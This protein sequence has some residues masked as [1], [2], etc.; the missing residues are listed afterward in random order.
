MT[1]IGYG[2]F[3]RGT[4]A[5]LLALLV[6]PPFAG[7]SSAATASAGAIRGVLY[8][9]D[10][11]TRL[12]AATVTAINVKTGRRYV[13]NHTGDNGAYEIT[14]LPAGTYDIAI[15][16][17]ERVFVTDNLIDLAENQ[18]LYLSFA[19][20]PK[21]TAAPGATEPTD[22][23]GEA[24][25]TFTDP[26][27]VPQS[28]PAEKKKGFWSRPGGIAIITILVVGAFGAGVAAQNN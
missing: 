15:D 2:R 14:S 18:R 9:A 26:S 12:A 19:V 20:M 28:A 23:K 5:A 11:T 22:A 1:T 10:E 4:G 17:A 25:M 7:V 24:K 27:A 3:R 8:K 6:L 16:V 13:S 21:A